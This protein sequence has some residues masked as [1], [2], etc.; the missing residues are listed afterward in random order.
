MVKEYSNVLVIPTPVSSTSPKGPT[1]FI[2]WAVQGE[3]DGD[4]IRVIYMSL[5]AATQETN[6]IFHDITWLEV[7]ID[8]GSGLCME[9]QDIAPWFYIMPV[10]R[11]CFIPRK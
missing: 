3:V 5:E 9:D 6:E 11:L 7:D 1:T 8:L 4:H 2:Y 10:H